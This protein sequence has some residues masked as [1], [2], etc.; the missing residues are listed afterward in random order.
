M[1]ILGTSPD[2]I[3]LAE[4]RDRFQKLI[5][6]LGLKQPRE[7]HRQVR[8]QA[9]AIAEQIGFPVVIR[10]S[11]VL[12]GRAMEIVHDQAQLERYISEA[13]VVSGKSPVLIDRYLSDAIEI[14]VDA[15]ADGKDVF[16]CGIMEHI[17]EAGIHSGDSACSLP[18][19]SLAPEA[20]A[21]LKRQTEA[22]AL[23]LEVAG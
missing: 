17:E 16:I 12:G 3:D 7:R 5:A 23:A 8:K 20:I 6:R 15:L 14:D 1:P 11:Y 2:A 13:V 10:P 21:E 9:R 22:L 18:P 19:H 4:D